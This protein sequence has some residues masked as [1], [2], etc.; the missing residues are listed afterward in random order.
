MPRFGGHGP[1]Y[2]YVFRSFLL[3]KE[4]THASYWEKAVGCRPSCHERIRKDEAL[5][6]E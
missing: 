2:N 5:S 6:Q 3:R 4:L 1:P